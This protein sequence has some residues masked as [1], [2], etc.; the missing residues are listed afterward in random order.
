MQFGFL[1]INYK[2]A[3]MDIRD[4]ISFTDAGKL[5]FFQKAERAGVT[6]CMALSTCN[7]SEV[8]Y[9]YEEEEQRKQRKK[10]KK[11]T[12]DAGTTRHPGLAANTQR[13]T[14]NGK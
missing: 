12:N 1:G 2:S 6:Q 5:T 7:R 3:Q 13:L 8:Y 10:K 4:K 14:Q 11:Q 9:M